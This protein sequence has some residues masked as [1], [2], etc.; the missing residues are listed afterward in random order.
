MFDLNRNEANVMN[1]IW[2]R[3]AGLFLIMVSVLAFIGV[4]IMISFL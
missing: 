4:P 3:V 2:E 1:G